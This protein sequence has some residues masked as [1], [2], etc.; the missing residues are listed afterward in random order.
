MRRGV[1]IPLEDN[2]ITPGIAERKSQTLRRNR[3]FNKKTGKKSKHDR[4]QEF[5]LTK[6]MI[7]SERSVDQ[8]I[9]IDSQVQANS[10]QGFL[11]RR[12][13]LLRQRN[14]T[15]GVFRFVKTAMK[16]FSRLRPF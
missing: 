14:V 3:K 13:E 16:Y 12:S 9:D 6:G 11:I 7:A 2:E 15:R 5:Q 8:R 1:V 4:F 10:K